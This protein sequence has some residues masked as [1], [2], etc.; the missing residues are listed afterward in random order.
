MTVQVPNFY[1][2]ILI[3]VTTVTTWELQSDVIQK[4]LQGK[5][6]LEAMIVI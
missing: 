4:L 3:A 6:P 2:V 1:A 5:F